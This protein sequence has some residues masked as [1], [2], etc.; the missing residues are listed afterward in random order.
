MGLIELVILLA[1]VGFLVWL[2]INYIPMP[3]AFKKTI[4]VIVIVV[5]VLYLLRLFGVGDIPIGRTP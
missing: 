5:L 1:I 4:I 2:V 3:D